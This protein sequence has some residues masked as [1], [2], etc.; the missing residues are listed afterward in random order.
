MR[1]VTVDE[2]LGPKAVI[3]GGLTPGDRVILDNLQKVRAGLPV[4]P[5]PAAPSA[6]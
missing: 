6:K 2:I 5:R 3:I 1:P 4:V